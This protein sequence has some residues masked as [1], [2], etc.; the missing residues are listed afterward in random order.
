[1]NARWIFDGTF[2]TG[3][4]WTNYANNRNEVEYLVKKIFENRTIWSWRIVDAKSNK[5]VWRSDS[6][7]TGQTV[8]EYFKKILPNW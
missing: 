4:A 1:M 2:N 7:F 8:P 6:A 3:D 5:I